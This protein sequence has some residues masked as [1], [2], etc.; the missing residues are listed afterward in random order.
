M[1]AGEKVLLVDDREDN[2]F[3]LHSAL[4]PLGYPL[5]SAT[6]GDAAL[7]AVL[8]GGVAVTVLD[9]VMPGVSGLDVL[10]YMQRVEQTRRIPVILVTGMGVDAQ[11]SRT[12]MRLGAADLLMKPIDP[13]A[14]CIKVRYLHRAAHGRPAPARAGAGMLPRGPAALTGPDVADAP[15]DR[16]GRWGHP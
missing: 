9:V 13:W 14:L 12:A 8:R 5:E 7:K 3:A 16:A 6:S 2:L 11:L 15:V 1:P 10:R 4:S